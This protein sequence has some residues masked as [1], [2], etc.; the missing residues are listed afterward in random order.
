MLLFQRLRNVMKLNLLS[1]LSCMPEIWPIIAKTLPR[2]LMTLRWSSC[3]STRKRNYLMII[4][5]NKC[6][7]MKSKRRST[8]MIIEPLRRPH[9][10]LKRVRPSRT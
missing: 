4:L 5:K 7:K 1:R 10:A 2:I 6:N 3:P 9:L 8:L